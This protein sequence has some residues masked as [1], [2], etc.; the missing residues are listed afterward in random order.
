MAAANYSIIIDQHQDFARAFQVKIDDVVL[1]LTDHTFEAQLRDRESSSEAYDFTVTVV[2][3]PQGLINMI[4]SDTITATIK[5]GDYVYDLVMIKPNGDK[6][7]LLQG[8]AVVE[9]GVTR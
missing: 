4:M 6:T 1:D 7:R 2:D 5:S 8:K 3:A 9:A